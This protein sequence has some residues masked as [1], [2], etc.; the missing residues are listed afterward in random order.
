MVLAVSPATHDL[1]PE[2]SGDELRNWADDKGE[3]KPS[4]SAQFQRGSWRT[5]VATPR[6]AMLASAG[7]AWAVCCAHQSGQRVTFDIG[8]VTG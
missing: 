2:A 8:A 1:P 4:T 3:I 5:D 6:G 7:T